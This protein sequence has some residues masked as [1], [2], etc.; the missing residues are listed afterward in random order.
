MTRRSD[1]IHAALLRL[2][3]RFEF[4]HL[5]AETQPAEFLDQVCAEIDRLRAREP[6]APA[7]D[8][9]LMTQPDVS[10]HE[11]IVDTFSAELGCTIRDCLDCGCLVPGGPTR[12]KR[13]ANAAAPA[14]PEDFTHEC[15]NAINGH[16]C[17]CDAMPP[18]EPAGNTGC[19]CMW[20]A[21]PPSQNHAPGCPSHRSEPAGNTGHV[22][23][24]QSTTA[25]Y[26]CTLCDARRPPTL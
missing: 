21:S 9:S 1:K 4:G 15:G 14:R 13:C 26:Y 22:H 19:T 12:C 10:M 5:L 8:T 25:G 23:N 24:W 6:A 3:D 7:L 2:A 18:R 11:H 16:P 20:P 17:G